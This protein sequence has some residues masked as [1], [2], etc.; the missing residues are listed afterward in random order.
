MASGRVARVIPQT[1]PLP[2]AANGRAALE[3]ARS[4]EGGTRVIERPML[5]FQPVFPMAN[6]GARVLRD[7]AVTFDQRNNRMRITKPT[8]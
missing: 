1:D 3:R 7:L 6:V 2:T 5:D 8:R 4:D